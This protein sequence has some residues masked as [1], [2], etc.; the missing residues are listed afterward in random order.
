M[1]QGTPRSRAPL[2]LRGPAPRSVLSAVCAL[3]AACSGGGPVD[4]EPDAQVDASQPAQVALSTVN[5]PL[6][7]AYRDGQ[8]AWKTPE[9][10]S[11]GS[12]AFEVT[13]PY[14]VTVVC[15]NG[16][17][18]VLTY[19]RARTPD[20]ERTLTVA[21]AGSTPIDPYAVFG[22]VAQPGEVHVLQYVDLSS[23]PAWSYSFRVKPGTYDL[24]A[25]DDQWVVLRRDLKVV[26]DHVEVAPIDLPLEGALLSH[27]AFT[28]T[29]ETP[30][31]REL[32]STVGVWFLT[33]STT[34]QLAFSSPIAQVPL[35]PSDRLRP[36]DAHRLTFFA[37]D[38]AGSSRSIERPH[39]YGQEPT[40][41]LPPPLGGPKLSLG[42]DL[43]ASW[44][45]LPE[46][47][48]VVVRSS[49][50][51]MVTRARNTHELELSKAYLAA[52][53]ATTATLDTALPGYS[54]EWRV[55]QSV[56]VSASVAA[57]RVG[58]LET[59]ESKF[60]ATIPPR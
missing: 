50:F 25:H 32:G 58:Q 1:N 42:R 15:S 45:S 20:D 54:A 18:G 55:D 37:S 33:A 29:N 46:T 40:A 22:T 51:S 7:V 6:F 41:T 10:V 56:N 14:Q 8:A 31:E 24:F 19:Q 23:E 34:G 16:L 44:S 17:A 53:G 49:S 2:A 48:T 26:D 11:V 43:V 28:L 59:T 21:C 39:R 57:R 9:L 36:T 13:G 60:S 12:Y 4:V 52:T 38:R 35:V 47:D 30:G 5:P 3:L 27:Q